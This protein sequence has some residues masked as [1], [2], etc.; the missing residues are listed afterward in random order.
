[1][2]QFDLLK[3]LESISINKIHHCLNKKTLILID[4]QYSVG[5]QNDQ[6]FHFALILSLLTLVGNY[7]TSVFIIRN[8]K[9]RDNFM[10]RKA[11]VNSLKVK[12]RIT[13]VNFRPN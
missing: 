13:V 9:T 8:A 11:R 6:K 1:M 12:H 3:R 7:L 2:K 10:Q 5:I 4:S